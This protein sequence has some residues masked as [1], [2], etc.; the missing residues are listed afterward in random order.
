MHS[1][2][3]SLFFG[4]KK[5]LIININGVLCYFP[6]LAILQGNDRVF[7]RNAN[8]TKVEVRV[9]VDNFFAKA[10]KSFYITIWS[11][12]KFKHVL[13]ALPMLML[14]NFVDCFVFI[15]EHEECSK[16]SNEISF[17]SHYYLK[18]LKCVYYGCHMLPYGKADQTL[19]IDDEPNKALWNPN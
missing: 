11:C 18:D 15:W 6:H 3:C 1:H 13:E 9:G 8:K 14:N 2:H 16:M 4:P 10:F 19:L 17:G 12:M 5:M 7:G